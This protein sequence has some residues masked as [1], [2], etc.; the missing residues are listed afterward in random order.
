M[1]KSPPGAPLP[2]SP[3][4]GG[5]EVG[6]QGTEA[7]GAGVAGQ[8]Q[9]LKPMTSVRV[10]APS[11]C[12][13][14]CPRGWPGAA[15]ASAACPL[16]DSLVQGGPPVTTAHQLVAST[17]GLSKETSRTALRYGHSPYPQT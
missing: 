2:L 7:G 11:S 1:G 10:P 13:A 16:E 3:P 4:A 6:V 12:G 17:L 8:C 9:G 5:G 14:Q 15:G